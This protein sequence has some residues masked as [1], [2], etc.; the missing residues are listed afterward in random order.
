MVEFGHEQLQHEEGTSNRRI[1]FGTNA[2]VEKEAKITNYGDSMWYDSN[3]IRQ[4][5][6]NKR[7]AMA[8]ISGERPSFELQLG[9]IWSGIMQEMIFTVPSGNLI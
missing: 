2:L 8:K 6:T 5:F 9:N 7:E 3:Q 4:D 1:S